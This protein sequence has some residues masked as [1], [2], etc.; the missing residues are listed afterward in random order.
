MSQNFHDKI[1]SIKKVFNCWVYRKVSPYGK[2]TIIK[3]L[4]L[5]KLSYVAIVLPS[6]AKTQLKKLETICQDFL[7]G[8]KKSVK[9]SKED[10][11]LTQ[12]AGGLGM[13]SIKEFWEA[14]K[15]SWIRRA[16]NT[17]DTWPNILEHAVNS[18]L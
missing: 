14:L 6:L 7:W 4:A 16:L 15:F 3:S 12:K 17:E 13:T 18:I 10:A 8:D 11:C 5:S 2:I 9:V 1:E